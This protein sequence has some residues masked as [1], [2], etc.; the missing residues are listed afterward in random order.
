MHHLIEETVYTVTT[1][2]AAIN[3]VKI[4]PERGILSGNNV[5]VGSGMM[6]EEK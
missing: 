5:E 3:F 2:I 4:G 6:K 1:L